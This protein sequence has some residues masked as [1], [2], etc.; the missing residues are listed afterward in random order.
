[1]IALI[2]LLRYVRPVTIARYDE[3]A[4]FYQTGWPDTYVDPVS[5]AL[6]DLLGSVR[7]ARVLELA[8]G[9]G[10]ITRELARR[11]A[12]VVG[13][14][15]SGA[16]LDPFS[17]ARSSMR[18]CAVTVFRTLTTWMGASNGHAR[19]CTNG[20]ARLLSLSSVLRAD[21]TCLGPGRQRAATTM[22]VGG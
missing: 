22:R 12:E 10:R 7:G 8:R 14:D 2:E 6:F 17:K 21:E 19:A 9:H 16:L 1:M 18:L 3:V 11:G 4:E 15:L 13:L 5:V 20:S